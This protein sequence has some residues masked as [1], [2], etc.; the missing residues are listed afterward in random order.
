MDGIMRRLHAIGRNQ[1]MA[2]LKIISVC[3]AC[4]LPL[5]GVCLDIGESSESKNL[6]S[7]ILVQVDAPN[8]DALVDEFDKLED[9]L[10]ASS[11]PLAE[12]RTFLDKFLNEINAKYGLNLTIQDACKLVRENLHTLQLHEETQRIILATIEL[13]GSDLALTNTKEERFESNV[14]VTTKNLLMARIYWPWEWNWFGLNKNHKNKYQHATKH[15]RNVNP[16][17]LIAEDLPSNCYIGGCEML[18]GALIFILPIPGAP[19]LG[20]LVVGDGARRVVDGVQQ[21]GD[22]RRNNPNYVPPQ[23]P[24]GFNF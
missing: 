5:S 3:M 8:S 4:F 9:I 10:D 22:E 11:D 23:N 24:P 15:T 2:Y 19:W 1:R 18:A 7:Q 16:S 13:Y 14:D 17:N 20:G 6:V 12:G 21:L